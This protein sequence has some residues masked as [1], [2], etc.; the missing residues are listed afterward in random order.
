MLPGSKLKTLQ[1]LI[2]GSTR[3]ELIWMNGYI[4]GLVTP[5]KDGNGNGQNG[6]STI[7]K[8][9][10]IVFGTETGNSKKLATELAALAKQKGINVKC[11]GVDQYRF[12]DLDK[13]EFFFVVIS[14]HGEGEPPGPAKK[15]YDAVMARTATLPH[16]RF[17]VLALGDTSYPLFC[18]T[19]ED[20]DGHF[21]KLGGKQL[22][23]L[24]K[25][26]VDFEK[27]AK[28]WFDKVLAITEK[29]EAIAKQSAH[30]Q[31]AAPKGEKKIYN[32]TILTHINLNDRGS[33]KVTWHI[34]IG[35]EE[36][37]SYEHGDAIAIIPHNRKEV[38][39]RIIELTG[40]DEHK[41]VE[42][43]KYKDSVRV[44]LTERL[45]ICY[46]LSSAI[47]K[48]AVITQ[49]DIPDT[50]MDLIDLLRI[51]PVKNP[52]QFEEVIKV[53]PVI[54][55]RL[56]SVSSSPLVNPNE[57]HLTVSR[58]AYIKQE[59]KHV[60]LCSTFLGDLSVNSAISF[61]VH[62]NRSFKL[63]A[64]DK[65]VIMIGPGT[66]IAPFRSFLAERDARGAAGQNWFFFGE[67]HFATD[68][69]YQSEMQMYHQT[70]VLNKIHLAFS[71]DQQEKIY[72][73]HRMFE[74]GRE[75]FEW[76]EGG[77]YVYISGTKDPMSKD[78]EKT[79]LDIIVHY[80]KKTPEEATSY[81][82][83]LKKEGRYHKDVY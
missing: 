63:P 20:I 36:P 77:A 1:E 40:I 61:Y 56:Y 75:L 4:S 60:G 8:K 50:R 81:W 14:T 2:D 54:A 64:D 58:H 76:L 80:G 5:L 23:P 7:V 15:F 13:E 35:A 21:S 41:V 78:V 9:I 73:Q 82:E 18:K 32:G 3:D 39:D 6:H 57:V 29:G 22:I 65:N 25:C 53:L 43:G 83:T 68:F 46:L 33:S 30:T 66:G 31:P 55:P 79:W 19:G 38:I 59:E 34:E 10:S 28:A 52:E 12:T 70:G 16:L 42:S 62:R 74:Q 26:D 48:Y 24:H 37:V 45:N 49:Q 67:Q 51:Y 17:A 71:R 72:V 11:T 47:K 44:L 69:L 27:P